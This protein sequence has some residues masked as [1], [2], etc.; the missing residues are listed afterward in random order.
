MKAVSTCVKLSLILGTTISEYLL[1]NLNTKAN[2][3]KRKMSK[4]DVDDTTVRRNISS[5]VYTNIQT[6]L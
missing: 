2:E 4:N 5:L 3:V 1:V 6:T